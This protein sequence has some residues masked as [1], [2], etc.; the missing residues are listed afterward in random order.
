MRFA[1]KLVSGRLVKRYKRFLADVVLDD[2]GEEITAHCANPGSML[3][4]NAPGSRV[5]L[6]QSDN[7]SRKLKYSWELVEA[8]GA[9]VG[10]NT[11][12]PNGLVEEALR[13]A[14][15][16]ELAG[17]DGLSRE[18]KYGRNS[19]ID[20][21]LTDAGGRRTYVEVKNVHLM[22]QPGL[23]EF[24]DSVTSRGAKH[25]VELGDM[26]EEGARAAMV[27][28][29]Q[30]PDCDILRLARD[31]DP[32]YGEAFDVARRRGVE[33]YAIGCRITPEEIVADR[34]VVIDE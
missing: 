7:P 34:A 12:H 3:G 24:P 11:A 15:L 13:A 31:I 6:S 33:V 32:A 9:L 28:L 20:I 26:V 19:R 10:I 21:L 2:T 22:R 16:A 14:R 17:F 4:L 18:V 5:W 29:V 8:D 25:L 27:Y 23:A 1:A 30:R